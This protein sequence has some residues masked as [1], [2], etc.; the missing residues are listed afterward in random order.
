[1]KK[2]LK[3]NFNELEGFFAFVY[4]DKNG[5]L[6]NCTR[7][8][9]GVKPLTYIQ[10]KDYISISSEASVLSD[11]FNLPYNKK[12]LEEYKVFRAISTLFTHGGWLIVSKRAIN[13]LCNSW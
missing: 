5:V 9:L 11:L 13:K 4:I 7:D 12:A 6:K 10:K 3:F 8:R 1:M 2:S